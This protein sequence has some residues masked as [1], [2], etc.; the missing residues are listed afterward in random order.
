MEHPS[1]PK[2]PAAETADGDWR[3]DA[4]AA[5]SALP[6]LPDE[7]DW[8]VADHYRLDA[9]WESALRPRARNLM[10][11]DDLADRPHACDLLLDQNLY[12]DPEL[13]YADRLSSQCRQLLGPDYALLRPEFRRARE[14]RDGEPRGAEA[15]RKRRL[16]VFFGGSDPSDETSKALEALAQLGPGTLDADVVVGGSNPHREKVEKACRALEGVRFHCQVDNMAELMA[17]A[18]VA[19]G[20]GGTTTW[21]R[22]CLGLPALVAVLADNQEE[23][24]ETAHERGVAVNLG[25]GEKLRPEDYVRALR[26]LTPERAKEMETRC[27]ALV[28]GLGCARVAKTI[29]GA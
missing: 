12:R 29:M 28:D 15:G 2:P 4:E 11:I 20:A 17:R 5:L 8:L 19:V 26:A 18:D 24:S 23:L 25:R 6:A 9:R 1:F 13:R 21:E 16:F 3:A 27:R 10:V 7:V 22:C 14:A